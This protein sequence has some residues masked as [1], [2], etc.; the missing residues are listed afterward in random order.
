[1]EKDSGRLIV[2]TGSKIVRRSCEG[3][4]RRRLVTPHGQSTFMGTGSLR[5]I[6]RPR[7]S[8][9]VGRQ[10]SPEAPG[11]ASA[12]LTTLDSPGCEHRWRSVELSEA[13]SVWRR[14]YRRPT[15]FLN[16]I[17]FFPSPCASYQ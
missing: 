2:V 8:S 16:L 10:T 1:M 4:A 3:H 11:K 13:P 6:R 17:S 12:T 7:G 5:R 15:G 14:G 9:D